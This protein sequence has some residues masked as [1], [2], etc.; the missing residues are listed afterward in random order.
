MNTKKGALPGAPSDT[1]T[2]SPDIVA[3]VLARIKAR[4]QNGETVSPADFEECERPA[5]WAAIPLLRD[6]LPNLKPGWKTVQ[7]YHVDG[8]R[9]RQRTYRLRGSID[10]LLA[11]WLCV[12]AVSL[13]VAARGWLG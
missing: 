12:A 13:L 8:L 11:G 1:A 7:E 10:P 5:F 4:I 6:E 2:S 9:L 3:P